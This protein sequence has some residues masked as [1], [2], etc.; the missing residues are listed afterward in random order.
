SHLSRMFKQAVG[1]SFTDYVMV[2]KME[3]AKSLLIA[4]SSVSEAALQLGYKDT[5]HFI[6]VFR[7]YWGVTPGE[8]KM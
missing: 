3:R 6:R 4:G 2:R 5:S 1:Q 7:K 8:L